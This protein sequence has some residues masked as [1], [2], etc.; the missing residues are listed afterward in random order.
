MA[1]EVHLC[2]SIP[3]DDA[4]EVFEAVGHGLGNLVRR[5]PDGETA[6]RISWLGWQDHVFEGDP[7]FEAIQSEGDYRA[8]TT[9]EWMRNTTWFKL[10][11]GIDPATVDIRPLDYAKHAIESYAQFKAKKDA[12]V[13]DGGARFMAAI[14]AP[15]NILN[16][17]IAPDD[18]LRIEPRFEAR[19]FGEI[20]EIAAAIPHNEF[21]LQWDCA[22][23][24]QAYDGA[25]KTY[26]DN[27]REGLIERWVRIGNRVPADIELGYHLCYG[28]LGGKHFVE[29]KDMGNM[30]E[31]ANGIFAGVSRSIEFIHMPVPVERDDDAYFEALKDLELP[32]E[33]KLF[34]GLVHD[35]D[36]A[37]G[38]RK[39]MATADKYCS[40]Y[41][42]ST[43]CGF[44]RREPETVAPLI[45]LHAELAKDN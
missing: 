20:D 24:M 45:G 22:Q 7:N 28:S 13:V 2:G 32:P 17:A 10:K 14:P 43:E 33:T 31:A 16:S 5:I 30:V 26:F 9:P 4:N 38:T 6:Q 8:A 29:P 11:D 27:P 36:G 21:A 18:R 3:L 35:S 25:R 23:D 42:I 44:G 15:F 39:R 1:M 37:A 34:L 19:M 40:D 12:G 41:G